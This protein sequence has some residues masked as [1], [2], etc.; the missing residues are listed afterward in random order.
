MIIVGQLVEALHYKPECRWFDSKC[1]WNFPYIIFPAAPWSWGRLSLQHKRIPE[2][3]LGVKA[4]G[5]LD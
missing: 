4:A 5:T 2:I 3:F 1:N